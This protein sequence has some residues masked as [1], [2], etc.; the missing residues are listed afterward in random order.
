MFCLESHKLFS[1]LRHLG[2]AGTH[3]IHVV[4]LLFMNRLDVL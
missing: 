4:V 3:Y 1:L 2:D